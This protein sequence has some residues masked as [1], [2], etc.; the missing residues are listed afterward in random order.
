MGLGVG[1]G[2]GCS[3]GGLE[4]FRVLGREQAARVRGGG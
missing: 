1:Q 3:G 4:V 2:L